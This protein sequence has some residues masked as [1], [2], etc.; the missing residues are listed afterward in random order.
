M[1]RKPAKFVSAFICA[2]FVFSA[3]LF[4]EESMNTRVAR[5]YAELAI[6][7]LDSD[8]SETAQIYT[9]T[10]LAYDGTLSDLWYLS[11]L[12]E[13]EKDS[14][15]AEQREPLEKAVLLDKWNTYSAAVARTQLAK[16]NMRT[17]D[18]VS[19]LNQLTNYP[20]LITPEAQA[21]KIEIY[22]KTG[23]YGSARDIVED[24]VSL[25]PGNSSFARLF[26]EYEM[27]FDGIVSLNRKNAALYTKLGSSSPLTAFDAPVS[28]LGKRLLQHIY[29]Y[30]DKDNDILLYAAY[31][32]DEANALRY[33][34]AYK[35]RNYTNPFFAESA[36]INGAISAAEA[37]D[38]FIELSGENIDYNQLCNFSEALYANNETDAQ[39]QLF[40]YLWNYTG[41]VYFDTNWNSIIDMT[42]AYDHGLPLEAVYDKDNDGIS[43]WECVFEFGIP[44]VILLPEESRRITYSQY[45]A[46]ETVENIANGQTYELVPDSLTWTPLSLQ[47][48][49]VI[50]NFFVPLPAFYYNPVSDETILADSYRITTP[51]NERPEAAAQFTMLRG[52]PLSA[53]YMQNDAVYAEAFFDDGKITKRSVDFDDDGF[54]EKTEIYGFDWRTAITLMTEEEENRLFSE[55]FNSLFGKTGTY[56]ESVE[57]DLD[58]DGNPD[59]KITWNADGTET[60]CWDSPEEGVWN[61]TCT[62]SKDGNCLS[63]S[64]VN[65]V[66][67]A[68]VTVAYLDSEPVIF[69]DNH[70][71]YSIVRQDRQNLPKENNVSFYWIYPAGFAADFADL[72]GNYSDILGNISEKLIGL[73]NT[74]NGMS[75]FMSVFDAL[76]LLQE[77]NED[78]DNS[79]TLIMDPYRIFAVKAGNSIFAQLIDKSL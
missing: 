62:N 30:A 12:I 51:V 2:V 74:D 29:E 6:A 13:A 58:F 18:F 33:L 38:L 68:Q 55:L 41:N 52:K 19:A 76:S 8:D 15:P 26:F 77:N 73:I 78:E 61:M 22:Y 7:A 65:P 71:V 28:A 67:G 1:I 9:E 63:A 66:T 57:L 54:F 25:Y 37:V 32:A 70:T 5:R 59:Y 35:T 79:G 48:S 40:V 69:E 16:L 20:E 3:S 42:C 45:P 14:L 49:A 21:L 31:F 43:S 17:G 11:Y 60:S 39:D 47:L 27:A 72:S 50:E 24:S 36:Y 46:I 56:L 10:A 44:H 23:D 53:Q 4:C 34:D 64:F 75:S